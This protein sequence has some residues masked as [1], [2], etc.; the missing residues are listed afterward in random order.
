MFYGGAMYNTSEL[1]ELSFISPSKKQRRGPQLVFTIQAEYLAEISKRLDLLAKGWAEHANQYCTRGSFFTPVSRD[2]FRVEFGYG[3]CGTVTFEDGKAH[4]CVELR[5]GEQVF[6]STLT[7]SLLATV[8]CLPI[9]GAHQSNQ[10]QQIDIEA[11]CDRKARVYGHAVGGYV[12]ARLRRWLRSEV[13]K[14]RGRSSIPMPQKVVQAM[15]ETWFAI[16]GTRF[17][18]SARDCGGSISSDGRFVLTCPGD[19][20]DLAIYPDQ[21]R[22]DHLSV[23][24]SCHNLDDPIQQL[25]LLAGLARLC[26]LAR[27]DE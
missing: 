26:E 9:E 12:S 21:I 22:G 11:R 6:Q 27:K 19:A 18:Q 16:S 20:C 10:V 15:Q 1:Y 5:G 2:L 23:R 4:L 3:R 14:I 8:L 17:A 7:I 25:T 13:G 24:F